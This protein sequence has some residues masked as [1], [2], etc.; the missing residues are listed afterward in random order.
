MGCS[1]EL[2]AIFND[3]ATIKT[4]QD[5][6]NEYGKEENDEYEYIISLNYEFEDPE[7]YIIHYDFI[8]GGSYLVF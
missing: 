3:T 2:K 1:E 5:L 7:K 4:K 6:I 8:Y